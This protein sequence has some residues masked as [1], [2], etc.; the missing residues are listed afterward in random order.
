ME[1][2]AW[3]ECGHTYVSEDGVKVYSEAVVGGLCK[4]VRSGRWVGL[5]ATGA[6]T[7]VTMRIRQGKG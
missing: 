2:E 6:I 4:Q 7:S 1:V 3:G 5:D